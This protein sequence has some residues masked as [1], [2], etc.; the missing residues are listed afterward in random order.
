M[1]L[2]TNRPGHNRRHSPAAEKLGG[3]GADAV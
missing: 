1:E 2:V 3:L